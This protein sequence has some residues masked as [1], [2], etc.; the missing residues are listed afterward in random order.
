MR[1]TGG[2]IVA[3]ALIAHG[4]PYVIGIPGH[5]NLPLVDA[6]MTR[7]DRLTTLT[8]KQ[9]MA[10]VHMADG[11]YR[12]TGQ[13]LAA[14]TS[15]GPGAVNTAIGLATCYVES[16]AVLALTGDTH[17]HMFGRGVLQEIERT[18]SS[19]FP[20]LLEPVVK[21]YWQATSVRQLPQML[22]RAFAQM[23]T[24]R[25][26]PVLLSLPMDVQAADADVSV[27]G[28]DVSVARSRPSPPG[29]DLD[30]AAELLLAAQRPVIVAGGG[31]IG[32]NACDALRRVAEATGAAVIHTMMA[33]GAFPA[34]HP[35]YAWCGGSKGTH[36]GN[37]LARSADVILAVGCRFADETASSYR[38]GVT[39]SI[40]PTKLIHIDIDPNEIGKNY[41]V[42]VGLVGDAR[43]ALEGLAARL[44]ARPKDWRCGAYAAEIAALRQAWDDHLAGWRDAS[45]EPVMISNVLAEARAAL[46]R[47]AVV[48][49]SSGNIQAQVIQEWPCYEPRTCLSSGGFSTMGWALPAALGVRLA[50]P[51]REIV[52]F[53]GDGDFLMTIQELATAVEHNLPVA[54]LLVNNQGWKSIKDLQMAAY[55]AE[56]AFV[57]DFVAGGGPY[58]P[59]FA[60]IARAFGCHAERVSRPGEVGPALRRAVECGRPA[61]VEVLVNT[62]YPYTGSPAVG[63]WDVPVPTYLTERRAVY[64]R[65]A[66]EERLT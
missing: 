59:D 19:N 36:C 46:P 64:E 52:A 7:R 3:E 27:R 38:P 55:G 13:P 45:R 63:W 29:A 18:H 23:L 11:Y 1:L 2:E 56:R 47:D 33:I 62:E 34:D 31:V 14:F 51:E 16:T 43:A 50:L 15:I 12:V 37:A 65:E 39:Y 10:A 40:P 66:G 24:G 60:A 9:E 6:F 49:V 26:G 58:S 53:V 44:E 21:R 41:P 28:P 57:T 4:V 20:R 8:V 61:V 22:H 5:G 17:V 54:V 30:R 42:E 48:T 32:A 25:P 35:L